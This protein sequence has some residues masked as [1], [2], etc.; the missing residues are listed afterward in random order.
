MT[1]I[2]DRIIQRMK[3]LNIR[4]VDLVEATG[5]TKGAV[6][7]WVAGTNIPKAEYLPALA[8]VLKTSQNW[9]LTGN[10][11]KPANNF[12]IRPLP[13]LETKFVAAN[14]LIGIKKDGGLFE[15]DEVKKLENE[16]KILQNIPKKINNIQK[17]IIVIE[18]MH[19]NPIL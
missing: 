19:R 16:L 14:T 12:N 17:E 1:S 9:L 6:S 10:Q 5:A 2:S 15:T 18:K 11:E 7:K 3:E 13:N 4:Q 8:T